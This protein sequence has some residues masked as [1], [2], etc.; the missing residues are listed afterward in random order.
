VFSPEVVVFIVAAVFVGGLSM[1]GV[2][3]I[4]FFDKWRVEA[5]EPSLPS[6]SND[7]PEVH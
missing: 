5:P 4:Y 7:D 3:L 1:G 6:G 2:T